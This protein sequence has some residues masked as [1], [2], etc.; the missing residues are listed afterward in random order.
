V[1]KLSHSDAHDALSDVLATIEVARLVKQKQ[2]KLFKWLLNIRA[3]KSVSELVEAKEPFVYTSGKYGSEYLHTT[4]V[5]QIGQ[6][7]ERGAALV[8]DLRVDPTPFLKMSADELAGVWKFTKDPNAIRLPIKTL[9]YNRCP[10]VAPLSVIGDK[11]VRERLK[12]DMPAV[13]ANLDL[14]RRNQVFIQK[15]LQALRLLDQQQAQAQT[16]LVDNPL[17]V[18][19]RLY[20]NFISDTD[21]SVMRALRV[22]ETNEMADLAGTFKDRRLQN[23]APLYKARNYPASLSTEERS[24]WDD[25]CRQKLL[26]GGKD[27]PLAGYFAR[28]QELT[29]EKLPQTKQYLLEEL[30]LYGESII[31]ADAD[32]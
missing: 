20:D 8:Y 3:K 18:D 14:L 5:T 30:K 25:F 29:D 16:G 17:T 23:L 6:H 12:L 7:P 11:S 9:K 21:K 22:A 26:A 15:V 31:P 4:V 28:L 10:A 1:N 32:G 24:K 13:Q 2:P 27:S 19:E